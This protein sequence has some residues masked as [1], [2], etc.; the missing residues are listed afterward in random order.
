[1]DE[2]PTEARLLVILGCQWGRRSCC[3]FGGCNH[4]CDSWLVSVVS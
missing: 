2:G 3:S 1:M 4:L